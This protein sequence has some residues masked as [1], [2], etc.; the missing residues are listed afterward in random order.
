MQNNVLQHVL[1]TKIMAEISP[2][3]VLARTINLDHG[4]SGE[5]QHIATCA[6]AGFPTASA[7]VN[8]ADVLID[9]HSAWKVQY[10]ANAR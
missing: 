8:S 1:M 7:S 2:F 9:V 5:I 6:S 4:T 3:A 10:R